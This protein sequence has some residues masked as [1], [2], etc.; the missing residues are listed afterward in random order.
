M[1]K[2]AITA[3]L[4]AMWLCATAET[5]QTTNGNI[6]F[7]TYEYDFVGK[8]K[9]GYATFKGS[10][11]YPVKV[12]NSD[13]TGLQKAVT[14]GFAFKNGNLEP[15]TWSIGSDDNVY[16]RLSGGTV[17]LEGSNTSV[18]QR[19]ISI[20]NPKIIVWKEYWYQYEG[21]AHGM[22]GVSYINYDIANNK[23]ISYN[24]LFKPGTRAIVNSV[25]REMISITNLKERVYDNFDDIESSEVFYLTPDL[26]GVVFV[27]QPYE[28]GPYASG[29]IEVPIYFDRVEE[30]MT[31]YAK[32][33]IP[34][35]LY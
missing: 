27:Y 28:I 2:L 17:S 33:L 5:T 3:A 31:P 34:N 8:N 25:V 16:K 23:V 35:F 32:Q 12:G 14:E 24:D 15:Q 22:Y 6:G 18:L 11:V 13:I 4:A 7:A 26:D 9:T 20:L 30:A 29:V 10:L 19:D 21:G 1:R